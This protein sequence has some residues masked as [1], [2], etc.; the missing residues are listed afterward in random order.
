MTSELRVVQ[1]EHSTLQTEQAQ[2]ANLPKALLVAHSRLN[3][4]STVIEAIATL[5]TQ[6][7]DGE[8]PDLRVLIG[9]SIN[10]A[11]DSEAAKAVKRQRDNAGKG[12]GVVDLVQDLGAGLNDLEKDARELLEAMQDD[13]ATKMGSS[14]ATQ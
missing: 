6:V 7:L 8:P 5:C 13:L 10:G 9:A 3:R 14:C 11:G 1:N 12:T 4:T 2:L